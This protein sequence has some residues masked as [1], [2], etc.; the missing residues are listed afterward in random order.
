[1]RVTAGVEGLGPVNLGHSTKCDPIEQVVSAELL[2]P[3]HGSSVHYTDHLNRRNAEVFRMN[4]MR[5]MISV[6]L[7]SVALFGC[8]KESPAK[9]ASEPA[10]AA[11][12]QPS[13]PAPAEASQPAAAPEGK[14][15]LVAVGSAGKVEVMGTDA[16]VVADTEGF[17]MKLA[18]PK[19]ASKGA[20]VTVSVE[21][22]PK[23][24]F[25]LN[26]DFP[27]KL[28][29][30]PPAGVTVA[31]AEQSAA[32][33]VAFEPGHGTWQVVFTADS[34]GAKAFTGRMKFAVCTDTTCNPQKQDLAWSTAVQ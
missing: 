12:M 14:G 10:P 27:T 5:W 21:I 19:S 16:Q 23:A 7:C 28:T 26:K 4:S 9:A 24:G 30:T 18:A 1:V 17:T 34:A 25:H 11:T 22:T 32:D 13:P 8:K 15:D 29:V 33:A 3:A 6:A 2:G 31:K 20:K